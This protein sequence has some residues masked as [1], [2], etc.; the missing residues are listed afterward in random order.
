VCCVV[1]KEERS[2]CCR[3]ESL[4]SSNCGNVCLRQKYGILDE[5]MDTDRVRDSSTKTGLSI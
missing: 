5:L 4:E 2:R 3:H 1:R